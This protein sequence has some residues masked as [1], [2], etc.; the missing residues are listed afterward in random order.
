MRFVRTYYFPKKGDVCLE[1]PI[2]SELKHQ[3]HLKHFLKVTRNGVLRTE[4][5]PVENN[6]KR[7]T[8]RHNDFVNEVHFLKLI[9]L[10][11]S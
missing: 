2:F 10:F 7:I 5:L 4:R 3:R 9:A 1:E 8:C 11:S 6:L